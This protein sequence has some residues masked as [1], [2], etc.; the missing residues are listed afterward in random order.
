MSTVDFTIHVIV[1]WIQIIF[2]LVQFYGTYI[3]MESVEIHIS[4]MIH[5]NKGFQLTLGSVTAC[6]TA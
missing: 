3:L 1:K 2:G 4:S 5:N 6:H